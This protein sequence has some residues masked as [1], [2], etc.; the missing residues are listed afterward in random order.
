MRNRHI[1]PSDATSWSLCHR[2]VWF[3]NNPP[4]GL[5]TKIDP[6]EDLIKEKGI[7]HE[8][9][10]LRSL[11][12]GKSVCEAHSPQHT[13]ELMAQG[14]DIIYQG[15]LVDLQN[16][17][18]GNPDFL[19]KNNDGHYQPA[20][21]KL[22]N[23]TTKH[24]DIKVQLG[25]YRNLLNTP[26]PGIVYLGNGETEY[27]G[28]EN[29]ALVAQ[30]ICEMND[31]LSLPNPPKVRYSHS[32]CR[33]C[34]YF[35]ICISEFK[36]NSELSL[37]YGVDGRSVND[38][39]NHGITTILELA[40]ASIDDI[41]DIPY[42]KGPVK[43]QRAIDQA[44]SWLTGEVI[45]LRDIDLP[46]GTWIHFDIEDNPLD[47]SGEKHVYLWGF[48]KPG[49]THNDFE[50][51]WTNDMDSD[52]D[53]WQKFLSKIEEYKALY[54]DMIIAHYSFHEVTTIQ[55]YA[56]RYDME[57]HSTVKWLL[58]QNS[59]LFDMRK[60]VSDSLILPLQAYGLKDICK[61]KDLVNFQWEDDGAGSQWSVVQFNRFQMA[62]DQKEKQKLK[63]S[64][65]GYNR[66]DVIATRKLEEWLRQI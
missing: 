2:R 22:A 50:Y 33:A 49:Y 54:P 26:L 14:I 59:P 53:G 39:E 31:I 58:G 37:I 35:Q 11:S 43:K 41:P 65:L 52:L 18:T 66:D 5:E 6:F 1:T 46:D 29:D 9:S 15:Q 20:D 40:N 23:S 34:P 38:L 13:I 47:P 32:K 21:A 28:E 60:S 10:V 4:E 36:A 45:K 19:L 61:H 8:K 25:V 57:D 7:E 56:K 51:I 24:K 17:I 44:H 62:S 12:N 30:F 64:I 55:K 42:L 48:L 16:N 3:D 63:H 27:L